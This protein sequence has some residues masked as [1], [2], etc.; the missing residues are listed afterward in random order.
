MSSTVTLPAR[1]VPKVTD[2]VKRT[3]VEPMQSRRPGI[4]PEEL[5]TTIYRAMASEP[6]VV[7]I[8]TGR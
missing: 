6:A 8:D 1:V 2:T 4:P 7:P 3:S 5:V